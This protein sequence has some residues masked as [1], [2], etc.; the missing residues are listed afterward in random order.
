M[1]TA[2]KWCCKDRYP[3][4]NL[5]WHVVIDVVLDRKCLF[6]CRML[7]AQAF[8]DKHASK[9]FYSWSFFWLNSLFF[10]LS[11]VQEFFWANQA[12]V[13][14]SVKC[15]FD[16]PNFKTSTDCR[17]RDSGTISYNKAKP[18]TVKHFIQLW[19]S[20]VNCAQAINTARKKR[21]RKI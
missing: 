10:S 12:R 20:D 21:C 6:L 8:K 2:N 9:C 3:K 16:C 4:N 17:L 7:A 14:C 1:I 15:F 13:G 19:L 11:S 18:H 5:K